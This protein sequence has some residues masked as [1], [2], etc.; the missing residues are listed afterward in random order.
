L[1]QRRLSARAMNF[2]EHKNSFADEPRS[3]DGAAYR[4]DIAHKKPH[5]SVE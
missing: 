4:W 1:S 2:F 5:V 3:F